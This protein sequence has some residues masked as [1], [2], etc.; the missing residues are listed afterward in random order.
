[1]SQVSGLSLLIVLLINANPRS[2]LTASV[3]TPTVHLGTS[4]FN[5]QYNSF[6]TSE[7]Q[8]T[9]KN[10]ISTTYAFNR[11]KLSETIKLSNN[12]IVN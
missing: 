2:D 5:Q 6:T 1:M 10:L 8:S 11:A 3:A 7:S 12:N 4:Y 9:R